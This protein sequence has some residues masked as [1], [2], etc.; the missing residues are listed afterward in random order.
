[1]NHAHSLLIS[2]MQFWKTT[3]MHIRKLFFAAL[4]TI[5]SLAYSQE[6]YVVIGSFGTEEA[7]KKFMGYARSLHYDANYILN[8]NNS[9]F[10]VYVLK[11]DDRKIASEQT[12]R[13]QRETEF[14]DAWMYSGVQTKP[15][16]VVVKK[17]AKLELPEAPNEVTYEIAEP[18]PVPTEETVVTF[19]GPEKPVAKG[20]FFKFQLK[21]TDGKIVQGPVYNVDRR[22]G[23][24]LATYKANE[25]IDV[26]RPSIRGVPMTLVV[27]IFGY[28]E[29][30]K[31]VDYED[32]ALT[33]G[34]FQDENGVWIIPFELS[35]IKK[36]DVTVM[37]R[38]SFYKDA[39][40]M[41]PAS[42]PELD[43]LV[44]LMEMNPSF[45]IKIHGHNNGNEKSIRITTLGSDKN[46]FG[47]ER[48]LS[49]TGNAKELSRLRAETIKSYLVDRGIDKNRIETF[50]WGGTA[51]L[52]TPGT[53]AA[54]R[55]N[56]RIEVEIIKD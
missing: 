53:A 42:K 43:A 55:L 48:S 29:E 12:F 8:Q 26:R 36:G 32:P 54:T 6:Y 52:A 10:Y 21:N 35:R 22:L 13:L 45:V 2:G 47:M 4:L 50:A 31:F 24:D 1:M 5:P 30:I 17:E 20:K 15:A 49:V 18:E 51:M 19:E 39:V 25:F 9:L 14:T 56:N 40:I 3:G 41:T 11:S 38:V 46:Y 34:A 28:L 33:E 16:E 27:E 23:R 44:S 7:A 37:Y